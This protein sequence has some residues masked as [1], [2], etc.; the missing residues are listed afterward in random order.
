VT[1]IFVVVQQIDGL[2]ITPK[3]VGESVGLHPMTVIV[4]VFMWSLLM[5]GL[6]GAILAV[7]LTATLK[8]LLK[9][10]VWEKRL[11]AEAR[12]VTEDTAA[13]GVVE[14]LAGEPVHGK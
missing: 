2:F 9:R 1:G 8:V 3:I 11:R 12:L 7:P 6:L 4:S 13:M 10:Y 5:G 14:P